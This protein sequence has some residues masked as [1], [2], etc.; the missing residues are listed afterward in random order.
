MERGLSECKRN[1]LNITNVSQQQHHMLQK[2]CRRKIDLG[3]FSIATNTF[4]DIHYKQVTGTNINLI[5]I[6]FLFGSESII[7]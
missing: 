6:L 2:G 1:K 7:S 5:S 4:E 3:H